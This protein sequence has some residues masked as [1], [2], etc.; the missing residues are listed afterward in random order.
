LV[1][2]SIGKGRS[3]EVGV[4]VAPREVDEVGVG[5][6]AEHLGVAVGEVLLALA[7]LR[8]LGRADEGEVHRPEE[9]DL[10]LALVAL[11]VDLLNSLPFSRLTTAWSLKRRKLVADGQHG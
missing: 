1:S 10:P 4:V 5:A 7:E 3:L 9:E 6:R 11:V 8:D 2:A